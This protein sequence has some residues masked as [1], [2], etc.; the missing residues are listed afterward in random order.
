MTAKL[1]V[2]LGRTACRAHLR[3]P[4]GE[5]RAE[6]EGSLGL[7]EQDGAA[8]AERAV[9]AVATPLLRAA[10]V[11]RLDEVG[12]GAPGALSA[13]AAAAALAGRLCAAL[14]SARVAVASDALCS[15]AGALDGGAGLVLALGTGAV[16]VWLGA[17]GVLGRAD[18]LGPWLGDEGGGAAIGLSGLRAALRAREG[19]GPDT[20]LLAAAEARFGP[21]AALPARLGAHPSP[22]RLAAGFA[23][24]VAAAAASG[25]AVAA[26]ILLAAAAALAAT[27]LAALP[28]AARAAEGAAIPLALVGGLCGLGEG[29]TGPLLA[30]LLA[31]APRLRPA[32]APGSALDGAA[33]LARDHRTPHE[34]HVSR[35]A[36]TRAGTRIGTPQAGAHDPQAIVAGPDAATRAGSAPARDAPVPPGAAG[37]APGTVAPVMERLDALATEGVRPGLEDLDLRPPSEVVR[38]ALAIEREAGAALERAAP[39]L[40][41][42]A[43]AVA[44][45]LRAG[46]RLFYLGAGT[47]GRL[48]TLDAAE[49]GP[50]FDV[51]PG[52]VIPLL[53]GGPAAMTEAAEGAEDDGPAAV[54]A[55]ELHALTPG[56]A[57]VG[58]AASGRTPFV[59][60]GLAH[61]RARGAL[62]GAIVNN[63]GSPAAEAAE[64]AVEVLTGPELVAGSTRLSAGTTQKVALN[65]LSTAV[66]VSLG[67]TLGARMVDVR[68]TN[69]KLRRRA[70]RTTAELAGVP[71]PTAAQ[72]PG[73]HRLAGEARAGDAAGRRGRPG[74][75][76]PAGGGG[77]TGAAGGAGRLKE[78]VLF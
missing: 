75:P 44:A 10:G 46:G 77:R 54:A 2:D 50:T 40:G 36:G 70:L 53:A 64:L 71:E 47:P 7:A 48:A 73:G 41:R 69:A 55:L 11:A 16:A 49:L 60:A 33:L 61:A 26:A 9:L 42:L 25:D 5:L 19:R 1:A 15:H 12:V 65:A 43:E 30:A 74:G 37:D 8:L 78:A 51:A 28:E 13:P 66:M 72:R 45:R 17:D 23:P 58:I 24:D 27:G 31:G 3:W 22:P 35:A 29:L 4:G 67:K 32:P 52:L 62:T 59:V 57:V 14:P 18:G 39:A 34:A 38:L 20:S 56:D 68:A 63:P 6:G 76:G 21:L